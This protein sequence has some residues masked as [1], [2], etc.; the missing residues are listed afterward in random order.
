MTRR[1]EKSTVVPSLTTDSTTT[2][3]EGTENSEG[4]IFFYLS[5]SSL[6]DQPFVSI[7]NSRLKARHQLPRRLLCLEDNKN[8]PFS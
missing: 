8:C 2:T 3:K 6:L 1:L 4:E 5:L 7:L